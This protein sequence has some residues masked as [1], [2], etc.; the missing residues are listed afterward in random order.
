MIEFFSL[1]PKGHC[2]EDQV[3][4][5]FEHSLSNLKFTGLFL[6]YNMLEKSSQ[7]LEDNTPGTKRKK[8]L[9]KV[10][11]VGISI[12]VGFNI[13]RRPLSRPPKKLPCF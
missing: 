12:S 11:D 4:L 2:L 3:L 10:E 13:K 5:Q 9:A 6:M 8:I 7:L 1:M